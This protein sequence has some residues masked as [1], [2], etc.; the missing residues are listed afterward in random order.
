[1]FVDN[2]KFSKLKCFN[3][4]GVFNSECYLEVM[5]RVLITN[6][7]GNLNN[8]GLLYQSY[9]LSFSQCQKLKNL[10]LNYSIRNMKK[11]YDDYCACLI[12]DSFLYMY[13]NFKPDFHYSFTDFKIINWHYLEKNIKD[14]SKKKNVKHFLFTLE[15]KINTKYPHLQPE[16]YVAK[17]SKSTHMGKP[18]CF[19]CNEKSGNNFR[20]L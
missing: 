13:S 6:V 20:Y 4:Y 8:L 3:D 10:F 16:F 1:M 9:E 2:N 12:P 19:I 15:H 7:V 18:L 11:N 17:R 5:V 14:I